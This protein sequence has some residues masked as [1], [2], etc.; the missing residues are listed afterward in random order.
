MSNL[1]YNMTPNTRYLVRMFSRN[2]IGES[3]QTSV[4]DAMTLGDS[5]QTAVTSVMTLGR[6]ESPQLVSVI[7]YARYLEVV[8]DPGFDGGY[9]QTFFVEYRQESENTWKRSEPVVDNRQVRLSKILNN[10]NP[11]TRYQVRV[12]SKNEIG[13]SNQT[14]VTSVMTLAERPESPTNVSV[15]PYNRHLEV[16]W[17]PEFNGGYPQTFFIEYQQVTGEKWTRAGPIIDNLQTRMSNPLYNMTPNTQYLVRMFSRN[18]IGESNQTT[19]VAAMTLERTINLYRVK[20]VFVVLLI[21][22]AVVLSKDVSVVVLIVLAVTIAVYGTITFFCLRRKE[23]DASDNYSPVEEEVRENFQV[24]PV[25]NLLYISSDDS[26]LARAQN[27]RNQSI[28]DTTVPST[29]SEHQIYQMQLLNGGLVPT[30]RDAV[31]H[32]SVNRTIYSEID[33]MAEPVA[34]L[35]SSESEYDESDDSDT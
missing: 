21:M 7:P 35:S 25:D 15:I 12:F 22:I 20:A 26:I 18:E 16:S 6:P 3:N 14:A 1:L 30:M 27:I 10:L 19:V 4:V 34:P 24:E 31:I 29:S 11:K 28:L 5:N 32:G 13:D 9:Q 33:L 2:E 8:W 17:C 23:E